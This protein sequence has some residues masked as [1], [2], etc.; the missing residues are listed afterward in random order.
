MAHIGAAKPDK[1]G[2]KVARGK[3]YKAPVASGKSRSSRAGLVFPVGRIRRQLKSVMVGQR[4]GVG[5]S[6]YM[7]AVLEYL[8]A[9]LL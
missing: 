4:V 3:L 2:R 8:T 5:S 7:A 9:E 6:V 1:T